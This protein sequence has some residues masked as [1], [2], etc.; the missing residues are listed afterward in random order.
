MTVP[1]PI[2]NQVGGFYTGFFIAFNYFSGYNNGVIFAT[3]KK[4]GL[5]AG[6]WQGLEL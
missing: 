5:L 3:L 2:G 6:K 4:A 1:T